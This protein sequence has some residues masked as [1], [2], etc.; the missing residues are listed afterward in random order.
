MRYP[1]VLVPDQYSQVSELSMSSAKSNA[2]SGPRLGALLRIASQAMTEQFSRWITASGFEGIQPAHSAVIQPL[3]N[4]PGGVRIT[5]LAEA[6]RVT[7]QTMSALV[8]DLE[9][10]GYVERV[11]DPRDARANLIRLSQRGRA[12]ASAARA[13]A[14]RI[15]RDWAKRIGPDR[16]AE[17][18]A[19]LE[20]LRTTVLQPKERR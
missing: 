15:E 6:A 18:R 9:R 1:L 5:A 13:F 8:A 20:L 2:D 7:K 4:M 19:T 3:W 17:L 11:H 14:I 12:Y 10:A 16:M